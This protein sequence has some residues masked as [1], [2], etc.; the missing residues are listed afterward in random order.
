[1]KIRLPLIILSQFLS[2]HRID[3]TGVR[4]A[5]ASIFDICGASRERPPGRVCDVEGSGFGQSESRGLGATAFGSPRA[6]DSAPHIPHAS[7]TA[8]PDVVTGP[9]RSHRQESPHASV[10]LC[11]ST[12]TVSASGRSEFTERARKCARIRAQWDVGA[13][14]LGERREYA[15]SRK[16]NAEEQLISVVAVSPR[17]GRPRP[18]RGGRGSPPCRLTEE[19]NSLAHAPF[20]PEGSGGGAVSGWGPTRCR[21]WGVA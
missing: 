3:F 7:R 17:P 19:L 8:L 5:Q 18:G 12:H 1:M 9:N 13:R 6:S 16:S 20:S 21:R 11:I 4:M 2:K 15:T 10:S 14:A